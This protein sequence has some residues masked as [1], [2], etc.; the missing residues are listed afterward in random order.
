MLEQ[1]GFNTDR[2]R[3]TLPAITNSQILAINWQDI[4]NPAGGGAEVHFHEIFK[5]VAATGA[6]V[7]LLCSGFAGAPEHEVIDGIEIV[8]RGSRNWFN[9]AV[10][11]AYQALRRKRRFDVVIDDLNKIP[12]FTPWYVQ[13]PILAVLH[14]FFGKSIYL[15][16][17]WLAASY[18]YYAERMVPRVYRRVPF[19]AV[20]QSTA[21]E[22]ARLGHTSWIDLLPNAVEEAAYPCTSEQ[23]VPRR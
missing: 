3:T 14:H 20:S 5:R 9:W 4:R 10:P 19:A 18:V 12:F 23:K 1:R 21:D 11:A 22:L 6:A 17:N 15:E 8:R 13:E 7:T 16:T 2:E